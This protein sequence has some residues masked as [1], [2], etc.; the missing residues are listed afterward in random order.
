MTNFQEIEE[1]FNQIKDTPEAL[2]DLR[3]SDAHKTT[4]T[5]ADDTKLRQEVLPDAETHYRLQEKYGAMFDKSS[6]AG[7]KSK[8]HG[9]IL[10]GGRKNFSD[11]HDNF[12]GTGRYK[13]QKTPEKFNFLKKDQKSTP[14]QTKSSSTSAAHNAKSE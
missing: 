4:G 2:D 8:L 5:A 14:T 6:R 7:A 13:P 1:Q 3:T 10:P 12:T 9:L 11:F